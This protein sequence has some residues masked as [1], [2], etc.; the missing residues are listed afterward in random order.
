MRRPPLVVKS[1]GFSMSCLLIEVAALGAEHGLSSAG[2]GSCSTWA[3]Q[4]W[5]MDLVAPW[6]VGSSRARN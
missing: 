3:Q 5:C 2:S 4:L 1:R 6:H